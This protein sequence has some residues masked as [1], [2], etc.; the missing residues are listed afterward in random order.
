MS[1]Q[2]VIFDL[3]GVLVRLEPKRL[4][5]QLAQASGKS[6]EQI[7]RAAIT[8]TLI[9]QLELGRMSPQQLFEHLRQRLDLPWA[10]ERFVGA[11]NSVLSENTD[12]TWVLPRLRERYT[13]LAL[14]NTDALHDEYIRRTWPVFSGVRHWIA[15]YQVGFRKPD[16]R[17]YQLAMRR[18]DAPPHATVYVDDIEGHVEAARQLGL[19]AIHFRD[20]LKLEQELRAVGLHV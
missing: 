5:A 1:F 7:E 6:V 13:L 16:P 15:S 11:W 18:A 14:T 3:G 19:T 2:L 9:E 20:G 4:M 17:I 8:P 12:T 10:F